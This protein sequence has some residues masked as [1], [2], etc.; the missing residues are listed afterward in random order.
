MSFGGVGGFAAVAA[1]EGDEARALV[2]QCIDAGVNLFDTADIYSGGRSEEILG[3][4]LGD[5]RGRVLVATKLHARMSDAA[6]DV[7]LSRRHI[8]AACEASLR[9]LGTDWIDLYQAHGYDA[10]VP[11]EET[12]RA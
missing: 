1:H 12:A 6:D 7:G 11:V 10:L 5:K 9:R 8:V 2:D 4:A 3:R